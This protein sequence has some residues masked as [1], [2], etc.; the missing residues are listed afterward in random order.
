MPKRDFLAIPDF[1][2][3]D[4]NHLFDVAARMKDGSDTSRPL[5]GRTLGMIFTKSSTRTRVS[6]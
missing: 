6:F 2:A 1:S 4:L 3:D 5:A